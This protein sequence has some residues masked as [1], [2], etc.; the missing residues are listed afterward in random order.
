RGDRDCPLTRHRQR[1]AFGQESHD[2]V[3]YCRIVFVGQGARVLGPSVG[4]D[5]AEARVSSTDIT[6]QPSGRRGFCR[7]HRRA[8]VADR[9]RT[10]FSRHAV[11]LLRSRTFIITAQRSLRSPSGILRLCRIASAIPSISKGL[12]ITASRNSRAAPA[13]QESTRTPGSSGG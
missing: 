2:G 12:T 13:K 8:S 7:A 11:I 9:A 1:T 4:R 6:D 10:K 5:Q 3:V